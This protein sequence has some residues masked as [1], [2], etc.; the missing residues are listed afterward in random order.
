M[1]AFRS[2]GQS[3]LYNK[4][5]ESWQQ[6]IE[7]NSTRSTNRRLSQQSHQRSRINRSDLTKA[8]DQGHITAINAVHPRPTTEA[9]IVYYIDNKET[10]HSPLNNCVIADTGA[11]VNVCNDW[12]RYESVGKLSEPEYIRAGGRVISIRYK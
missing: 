1:T 11:S 6:I 8:N 10:P 3:P 9:Q 7:A 4:Q 12:N 5:P 2:T